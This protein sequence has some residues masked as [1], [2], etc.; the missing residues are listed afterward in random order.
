MAATV[1]PPASAD[2]DLAD[3]SLP[4]TWPGSARPDMIVTDE[5]VNGIVAILDEVR[6]HVL[7]GVTVARHPCLRQ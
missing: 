4:A 2:V 3:E 6:G 5:Q 7:P 1:A